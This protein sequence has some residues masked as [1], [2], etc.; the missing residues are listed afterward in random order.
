MTTTKVKRKIITVEPISNVS[1]NRFNSLMS[2]LHSCYV[3]D[4]KDDTMYLT[5]VNGKYKFTMSTKDDF[6]WRIIK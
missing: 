1:K 6:N 5:S 4:E 3:D 2:N